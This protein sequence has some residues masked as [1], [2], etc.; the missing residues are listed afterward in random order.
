V[1]DT[2]LMA[3]SSI[4]V[5]RG[6][7]GRRAPASRHDSSYCKDL[8]S[9]VV[10]DDKNKM[11]RATVGFFKIYLKVKTPSRDLFA[12]LVLVHLVVYGSREKCGIL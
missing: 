11:G 9:Q 1:E 6:V 7:H 10:Q 3:N 12:L 5:V 8:L 2:V 4:E